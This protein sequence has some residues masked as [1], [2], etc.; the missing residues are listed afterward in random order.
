MN[1]VNVFFGIYC[2]ITD[3]FGNRLIQTLSIEFDAKSVLSTKV[4][5]EQSERMK[6]FLKANMQNETTQ[7][8]T[9]NVIIISSP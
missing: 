7:N 5:Y 6:F 2:N 3:S 9:T 8:I 1:N 4:N